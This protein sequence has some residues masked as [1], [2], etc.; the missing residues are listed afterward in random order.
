MQSLG[1]LRRP[2]PWIGFDA[3]SYPYDVS[4]DGCVVVGVSGDPDWA[5]PYSQS[6]RWTEE[7]G[8]VGLGAGCCDGATG[9]SADGSVIAGLRGTYRGRWTAQT[10]WVSLGRIPGTDRDAIGA[11]DVSPDGGTMVG[12]AQSAS[13]FTLEA[14]IWK[15][16]EGMSGLGELPGGD[17]GSSAGALSADGLTV[18]GWS[19]SG[20]GLEAFRWTAQTGM[21]GLGFLPGGELQSSA[22]ATS[23]DGSIV[24]GNSYGAADPDMS[25]A[26][27]WDFAHGMRR[28]IDFLG[29][30]GVVI[31]GW[32]RI[33]VNGMTPD[34]HSFV[35]AGRN[36]AGRYEAWFA[37]LGSCPGDFNHSGSIN[38]QDFFDFLNAF[39][40][41][42]PAADV[43]HDGLITSQDFF[44]F[45]TAFFAGCP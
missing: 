29:E 19:Q 2:A 26:F 6:F 16:G 14:F 5:P 28:L 25:P 33:G 10:G 9:V 7:A 31:P 36:P 12:V 39:F 3:I 11:G 32:T 17:Y 15:L 44:D 24:V 41:G 45:L 13:D 43:N 23:A 37:Y 34:G 8:M 35:G 1:T 18:V 40:A 20:S 4:A 27:I 30:N 21:L 38:S 42:D 22:S